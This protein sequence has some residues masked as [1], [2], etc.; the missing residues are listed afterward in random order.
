MVLTPPWLKLSTL[1][2]LLPNSLFREANT[3]T[4]S[5]CRQLYKKS[6][7]FTSLIITYWQR[8]IQKIRKKKALRLNARTQDGDYRNSRMYP[9]CAPLSHGV[10]QAVA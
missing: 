10:G 3:A 1:G 5:A 6:Y 2:T 9:R 8:R 4:S 7:R